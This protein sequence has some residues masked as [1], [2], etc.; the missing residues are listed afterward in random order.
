MKEGEHLAEDLT[1][2][3]PSRGSKAGVGCL[4]LVL[5]PPSMHEATLE[6][7]FHTGLGQPRGCGP[8]GLR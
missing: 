3:K 1:R 4:P 5:R 8:E 2:E 7:P 6:R